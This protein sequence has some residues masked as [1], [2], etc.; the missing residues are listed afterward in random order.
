VSLSLLL[1]DTHATYPYLCHWAARYKSNWYFQRVAHC[2]PFAIYLPLAPP[3]TVSL[4]FPFLSLSLSSA[5]FTMPIRTIPRHHYLHPRPQCY[6][7]LVAPLL[8]IPLTPEL[9]VSFGIQ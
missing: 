7:L 1:S 8:K 4:S 9:I 6:Q 5:R 2:L 3:L